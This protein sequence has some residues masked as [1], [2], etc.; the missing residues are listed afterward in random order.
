M[1]RVKY[2]VDCIILIHVVNTASLTNIF[3]YVDICGF[4]TPQFE[5]YTY[6]YIALLIDD[7]KSELSNFF[8]F[9]SIYLTFLT[10]CGALPIKTV[11]DKVFNC[12]NGRS[13]VQYI[14]FWDGNI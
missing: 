7:I 4:A 2:R 10:N 11:E 1:Y 5:P 14:F 13:Y 12:P 8:A 3:K 9:S 6:T